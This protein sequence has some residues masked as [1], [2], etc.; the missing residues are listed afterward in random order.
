MK[1]PESSAPRYMEHAHIGCVPARENLFGS[2][3]FVGDLT[4]ITGRRTGDAGRPTVRRKDRKNFTFKVYRMIY[5]LGM[6][7]L[8]PVLDAV[9]ANGLSEQLDKIRGSEEPSFVEWATKTGILP[10]QVKTASIYIR[11][12]APHWGSVPAVQI[13]PTVVG[14]V[15]GF[16]TLL[17]SIDQDDERNA[18]VMFMY[19]E[20]HI[21]M[22]RRQHDARH[23]FYIPW[24]PD[25]P[26]RPHRQVIPLDVIGREVSHYLVKAIANFMAIRAV[27]PTLKVIN[28]VCPPP[29]RTGA[30]DDP[31]DVVQEDD[32]ALARD[33]DSVRVKYYLLYAKALMEALLPLGVESLMPPMDTV[34]ADGL[35]RPEYAHDGVHGNALYGSRVAAQISDVLLAGVN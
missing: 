27:C 10:D 21:Y 19:G 15:P 24:R 17:E 2:L 4:D 22:G 3:K 31:D 28:V 32:P 20:E 18:L 23:D 11:Q 14:M 35:L 7:H 12:I 13:E 30:T 25:L 29:S 16:R 5:M 8:E 34:G 6:S 1:A 33:H 26:V 9:S